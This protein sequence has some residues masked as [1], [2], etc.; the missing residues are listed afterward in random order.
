[1]SRV[2]FPTTGFSNKNV[3]RSVRLW[4]AQGGAA[5]QYADLAVLD[6]TPRQALSWRKW[7]VTK[8]ES[9][10]TALRFPLD[11]GSH[12]VRVR[13][14]GRTG[15]AH[16]HLVWGRGAP[17]GT[18]PKAVK[19]QATPFVYL[20]VAGDVNRYA[21]LA[22]LMDL[23]DPSGAH[24]ERPAGDKPRVEVH[25]SRGAGPAEGKY[26]PRR[27]PSAASTADG[28]HQGCGCCTAA[29]AASC[30]STSASATAAA[31]SSAKHCACDQSRRSCQ[32][33]GARA[34]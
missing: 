24:A 29:A 33:G 31:S 21:P 6:P 2:A 5:G 25:R 1:V 13:G 20:Y 34:C 32:P 9:A 30:Y 22:S 17:L 11:D 10:A 4:A 15:K 7:S 27:S 23:C 12:C 26:C 3:K 14:L 28:R 19:K 8:W 16:F 18:A